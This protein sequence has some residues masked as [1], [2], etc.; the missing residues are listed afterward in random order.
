MVKKIIGIIAEYNPLHYGHIHHIREAARQTEASG[1]V[2]VLSSYFIQRGEPALLSKW[3][4]AEMALRAGANLVLELPVFFS[5]ANAG[6]FAGG[7]IDLLAATGVVDTVTF[8][9]EDPDFS[10]GSILDILIHEPFSF[11][12]SL[13]KYMK[14]G[15]SYVKARARALGDFD[16]AF[17]GFVSRPNNSLALAYMQRVRIK[18]YSLACLPIRREGDGYRAETVSSSLASAT[19]LRRLLEN[20]KF[21]EAEPLM[22]PAGRDV[23]FPCI[24][25]GRA[26]LSREIL[27][28]IARSLLSRTP[29]VELE[30]SAGMT[31]GME[32]RLLKFISESAS[33]EEF[34]AAAVSG[35][36]PAGR[37]RRQ[38][39]HFLLGISRQ[40]SAALQQEG[41]S[42]LR[43]L[44]ADTRGRELLRKIGKKGSLP[45]R[46]KISLDGD[47]PESRLALLEH[48]AG[49]LWENLAL[50]HV[51]GSEKKRRPFMG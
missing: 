36:Y 14:S 27:W 48:R 1:I 35:R 33:W 46:S 41:P 8:G 3:D 4:R 12:D 15:F 44:A 10:A 16:P 38:L 23:L 22:P 34:I 21:N 26:V 29:R 31:E 24:E 51:P 5:C 42:Y 37:V 39:I 47:S 2:V 28:R 18:K 45:V 19:A 43:P 25:G 13:K 6:V 30:R 7:G 40:E 49:E 20:N 32:N 17:E 50:R 11:K 9:M